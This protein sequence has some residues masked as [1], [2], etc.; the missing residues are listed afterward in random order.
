MVSLTLFSKFKTILQVKKVKEE[1][2]TVFVNPQQQKLE[3]K[4]QKSEVSG[5]SPL[6]SKQ[7]W[8]NGK[9]MLVFANSESE[10]VEKLNLVEKKHTKPLVLPANNGDDLLLSNRYTEESEPESDSDEWFN[11]RDVWI[12]EYNPA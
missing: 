6:H 11:K 3:K 4:K 10:L 8:I 1:D 12:W 7:V 9:P 5:T 2:A